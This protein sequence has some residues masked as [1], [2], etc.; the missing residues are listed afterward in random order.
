MRVDFGAA[1][2]RELDVASWIEHIPEWLS[3]PGEIF[4]VVAASAGWAQHERWIYNRIVVEPRLT[5]E[6]PEISTAP[7]PLRELAAILSDHPRVP[8]ESGSWG[9]DR[10]VTPLLMQA[11]AASGLAQ[12]RRAVSHIARPRCPGRA[13]SHTARSK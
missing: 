11:P 7:A 13:F 3:N 8:F 12:A 1:Q 2:R 5:A 9:S 6:F 10:R 4:D